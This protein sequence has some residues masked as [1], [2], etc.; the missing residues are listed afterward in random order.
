MANADQRSP[1]RNGPTDHKEVEGRGSATTFAAMMG[2]TFGPSTI[3][4]MGIGAFIPSVQADFGVTRGEVVLTSTVINLTVV[5]LSPLQGLLIDRFG[6]RRVILLSL[7]LFA[8]GL[9][10]FQFIPRRIE[11]FYLAWACVVALSVGL[12]PNGYLKTVGSWFTQRLGLAMGVANGGIGLG[13][14]LVPLIAGWVIALYDWRTAYSVLGALVLLFVFPVCFLALRENEASDPPASG[15]DQDKPQGIA[16]STVFRQKTL[17]WLLLAFL[18]LGLAT[19]PLAAQQIPLLVDKG[20]S[21]RRAA[22]V[23]SIFGVFLLIGRIGAGYLLDRIFAPILIII[24]ALGAA[25]AC[26]VYAMP[27][28]ANFALIPAALIGLT[29]GAEF[30]ALGYMVRR[31]FHISLFGRVYALIFAIFQLGGGLGAIYFAFS[32]NHGGSY[33]GALFAAAACLVVVSLV[34]T[35]LPRYAAIKQPDIAA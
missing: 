11:A 30:D 29:V 28:S 27:I 6:P 3:A 1:A 4:M 23:Q 8:L 33:R 16:L 14:I 20:L 15:G 9:M 2:L 35:R 24:L 25:L 5:L 10:S 22:A 34:L 21:L 12:L 26:I 19:S 18:G 32:Y 17:W 31:Y 13:N 7:P